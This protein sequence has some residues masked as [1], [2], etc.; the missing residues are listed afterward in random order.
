MS[1]LIASPPASRLPIADWS[2]SNHG[3]TSPSAAEAP[4][5]PAA[6]AMTTQPRYL[7]IAR[8]LKRAHRRRQLSGRR[9]P[10][11][12]A[13]AVRAV[14]HQPLHRARGGTGAVVGRPGHASPAR[15]H[16]R[17]SRH[18]TMRAITHDAASLRDLLQY[19]QD[20]ELRLVYVGRVALGKD[21]GARV[22]RAGR[23]KSGSTRSACATS[24]RGRGERRRPPDLRHPAVPQPGAA[25][26]SRPGCAIAR[27]RSTR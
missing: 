14:R 3:R 8:E 6:A 10:A 27:R 21:A 20:T 1:E 18:P 11:D 5:E 23:A 24:G 16:G 25:R 4:A 13:R 7:Q 15:R 19:A 26:A 2:C 17:R 22:R 9:P 12:R